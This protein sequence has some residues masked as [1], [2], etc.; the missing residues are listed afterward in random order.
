MVKNHIKRITAPTSW[1]IRRKNN[2][3]IAK[4]NAGA[5]SIQNG[6]SLLTFFKEILNVCK[7]SKE[8][9][10]V[11]NLKG[12]LVNGKKVLDKHYNVG[13]YDVVK[14]E[15]TG[16][17]FRIYF[18]SFGKLAV[19]AADN[20]S[21]IP[22]KIIKKTVIKGGKVQINCSNG[23]NIIVIDSKYVIGDTL[24]FEVPK[25]KIKEHIKLEKG[26]FVQI[27]EG[28]YRGLKGDVSDLIRYSGSANNDLITIVTSDGKEV[29][30]LKSY[31]FVLGKKKPVIA[32]G[33]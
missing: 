33:E 26:A 17:E 30:T 8:V 4:P 3:F 1:P 16:E 23:I 14:V 19:C 13:L 2:V 20:V 15:A 27:V 29:S 7:T 25:L 11:I 12:V 24:L 10:N 6:T 32:L 5:H 31:A 28:K 22:S 21:L 18:D 9:S